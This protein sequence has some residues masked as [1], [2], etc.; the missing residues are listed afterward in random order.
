MPTIAGAHG[1]FPS[2]APHASRL[3]RGGLLVGFASFGL[4]ILAGEVVGGEALTRS[5]F[6]R[7]SVAVSLL[8]G[9]AAVVGALAM[10]P[11]LPPPPE[12]GEERSPTE[13][14]LRIARRAEAWIE[15]ARRYLILGGLFGGVVWLPLVVFGLTAGR[16][17]SVWMLRVVSVAAAFAFV[18][19]AVLWWRRLVEMDR[20]LREWRSRIASLQGIE[21][22]LLAEP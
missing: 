16:G 5:A 11:T 15:R 18:S 9:V 17:S 8:G 7:A 2:L 14:F 1:V 3:F 20:E 12:V 21:K 13:S 22:E 4:L 19:V 10:P 6:A